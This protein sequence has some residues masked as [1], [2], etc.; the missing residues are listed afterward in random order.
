MLQNVD[1]GA[2]RAFYTVSVPITRVRNNID[3]F[4]HE[5][6]HDG[7]GNLYRQGRM[8]GVELEEVRWDREE[9]DE[10]DFDSD[11]SSRFPCGA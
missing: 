11:P 9:W 2:G 8:Q 7:E 4:L 3:Q 10:N 5:E 1:E 6:P